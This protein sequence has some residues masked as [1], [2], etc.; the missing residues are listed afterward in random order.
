MQTLLTHSILR[1]LMKQWNPNPGASKYWVFK[2]KL[3]AYVKGAVSTWFF[4]YVIVKEW[5]NKI[6]S[7]QCKY[8]KK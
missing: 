7:P 6:D 8:I 4:K 2:L 3:R 1:H 5:V